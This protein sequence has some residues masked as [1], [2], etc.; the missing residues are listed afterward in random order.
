MNAEQLRLAENKPHPEPWHFWGPYLAERAWGT[1]REDYSAN[2]DAW[3]Y[4]PHDHARSRTYR[5]NEDGIGGIS[6]YKG[7]L[8]FAFAFWNEHDPFLKERIFG[9]SGPEGNHGEDVKELYWYVDSTPSHSFMRMVYRYPQ[10]RFPYEELVA[11]SGARSKMEGE[12]EIWNTTALAENRYFDVEIEYAKADPHD[13]LI[14]VSA[15]NCGPESAPLHLL[16]TIWFRNTWSWDRAQPKPTLHKTAKGHA[17]VITAS[18]TVLG[19]YDLFCDSPDDLFFTE[20]ESNSERLWGIPN[21]TPFVKD[22]INDR[23]VSGKIDHVNSA[24]FGTK[25]AAYYKFNIPAKETTSIQLRLTRASANKK[26]NNEPFA[27]FEEIFTKRRAEA[28]EFYGEIAPSS[29]TEEQ[30]AVQRQAFAGLLWSKQFY[31]YIV[32]QWLDGDPDQPPPPDER[33][34]GRNSGWRHLYNERVMSMPDKWEFPWYASWDLAFHC[35]PLALVDVQF[36]KAQL[37]L[38][39][40]EWYQHPNGKV[41][42]YEWNFDDVNPPV[43]AWAAWRVYQIERKKTGKGDRAF[44]ETIFHKMLIAFTWWVNSKDSE[45]KNIFQG[46]F[47]GLD[48]IGVFDRNA[49]FPDG[50]HLEQSD[51][52]SWMGMFSL[53]LMRIA[54]ELARENHVY[55]NIATKFFEHFLMIAAA[56]NKLCGKGVGLW[57]EEDE[58]YYDVLH[59]PGGRN[60]PLRVRSLVGLMPLLAVETVQWQLIEAL[61]GFKSRLEWYLEYRPDLASLVS[62]WQEPGMKELR[63]VALTRGHRMKC[64]LRRMLDPEEFLSDYGVR[65]LSKFHQAHPYSITVRGEEKIVSYEPA[66]SQTGIFGGNSNWRG[67]VWLP[68]NYLLI[69]SLQQFHHY[70]GDDFK[71]E[72]P[73]GS[74]KLMHLKEVANEL[75]NRLIKIWLRDEN[76][77]RAFARASRYETV[78]DAVSVSGKPTA[79]PTGTRYLFHEYFHGD[80]GAGLGASHQTG[81]T[82]LVAK[83][84]QQQGEFGTIQRSP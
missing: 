50:T 39:V 77:E 63:L 42:A 57:D 29:L 74:G 25:A 56:M 60:L 2:G 70:Y 40:R 43:L 59:T 30:R 84:I 68:I 51:G 46:G 72:C 18:H 33:K 23:I 28:D 45:G 27:D 38:I 48:N 81:W 61:P 34:H 14:R 10:S 76:G 19:N 11:Q 15:K 6:D 53:N 66:E 75:S 37:D 82:G 44:L 64:L 4:F 83:L 65:S 71:V 13:I 22:S 9:V 69:E 8:C 41:P 3:N 26:T 1:V 21:S 47:L 35:I 12:F 17:A 54:I 31:H 80:I 49:Q 32:D 20:N 58:F 7:R 73:T 79:S 78:G 5:W 55:E 36:A 52:T 16:P 67:P 24:G 62:R